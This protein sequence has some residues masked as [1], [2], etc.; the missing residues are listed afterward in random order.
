ML[1]VV[2]CGRRWFRSRVF[3]SDL[4][5]VLRAD[6]RVGLPAVL[7]VSHCCPWG[8]AG[9]QHSP[10]A[11]ERGSVHRPRRGLLSSGP[12][13]LFCPK[14]PRLWADGPHVSTATVM[15]G[16]CLAADAR[17]LRPLQGLA[18]AEGG[19]SRGPVT[20]CA[21]WAYAATWGTEC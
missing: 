7:T 15:V 17:V 14:Q 16:Q 8:R 11:S 6:L 4:L 3:S 5:S 1:L 18:R 21:W 19:H 20:L 2:T 9:A 10:R 13:S 12:L